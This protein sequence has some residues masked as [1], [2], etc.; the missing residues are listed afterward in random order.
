MGGW[1]PPG[2]E[3]TLQPPL[4]FGQGKRDEGGK[5]LS[6]WG[7]RGRLPLPRSCLPR[8]DLLPE[9][10]VSP[11]A[12]TQAVGE[13]VAF[14]GSPATLSTPSHLLVFHPGCRLPGGRQGHSNP[15][16]TRADVA[17]EGAQLLSPSSA[18]L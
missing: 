7:G 10:G 2:A 16:T 3:L 4:L 18:Q 8:P 9:A 6:C 12:L 13:W 11:L 17:G 5:D 1:G 14:S 15:P